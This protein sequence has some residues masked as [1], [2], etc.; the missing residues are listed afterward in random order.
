MSIIGIFEDMFG[1]IP[2]DPG[3]MIFIPNIPPA[4]PFP[5]IPSGA[6]QPPAQMVFLSVITPVYINKLTYGSGISILC[7]YTFQ[8]VS[9]KADY[10][11]TCQG[12]VASS[13]VSNMFDKEV[14]K[15]YD[16]DMSPKNTPKNPALSEIPLPLV[17]GNHADN[18]HVE[19]DDIVCAMESGKKFIIRGAVCAEASKIDES[20]KAM[21]DMLENGAHCYYLNG[22]VDGY[23]N[24]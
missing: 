19:G 4:P 2:A 23:N 5:A 1:L 21:T 16:Q 17:T 12:Q 22:D 13:T 18:A 3:R 20:Y 6:F 14:M 9:M 8:G 15:W 11:F 10:L 7:T 24:K